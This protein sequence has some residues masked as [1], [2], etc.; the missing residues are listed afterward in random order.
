MIE[1]DPR[2]IKGTEQQNET[3]NDTNCCSGDAKDA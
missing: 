2:R 3:S 1:K